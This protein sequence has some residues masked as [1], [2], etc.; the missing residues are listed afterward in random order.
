M[1]LLNA[2]RFRRCFANL[3]KTDPAAYELTRPNQLSL[4]S[5]R[6][7]VTLAAWMPFA[8]SHLPVLGPSDDDIVIA[9]GDD[10]EWPLE[11]TRPSDQMYLQIRFLNFK[12]ADRYLKPVNKDAPS[13]LIFQ[14]PRQSFLE[15]FFKK[16]IPGCGASEQSTTLPAPPVKTLMSGPSRIAFKFGPR[17]NHSDPEIRIP[18]RMENLLNWS[19]FKLSVDPRAVS[20]G[21]RPST[22]LPVSPVAANQTMI[23][24]PYRLHLSPNEDGGFA[25]SS[26]GS[27]APL[28]K[29]C[30]SMPPPPATASE[31]NELWN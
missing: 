7:F 13:Y 29:I 9:L 30:A 21:A 31:W 22:S 16:T 28:P 5:R 14:L 1:F 11:L 8:L 3:L 17:Q 15:E 4:L 19:K 12:I 6:E 23:E 10:S 27:A 20:A 26:P 2:A 24:A 25:S 18:L